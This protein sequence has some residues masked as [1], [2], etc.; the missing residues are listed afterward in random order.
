MFAQL[1]IAHFTDVSNLKE[2]RNP[3]YILCKDYRDGRHGI[4]VTPEIHI[5]DFMLQERF[6]TGNPFQF[7]EGDGFGKGNLYDYTQSY[8]AKYKEIHESEN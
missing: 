6:C 2:S 3:D 4:K 8:E 5:F 7:K 1:T